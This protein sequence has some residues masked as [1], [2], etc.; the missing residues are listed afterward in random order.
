MQ[1]IHAL[2][3]FIVENDMSIAKKM[4]T[5]ALLSL[6]LAAMPALADMHPLQM[7]PAQPHMSA[8]KDSGYIH[9]TDLGI[10]DHDFTI[11]ISLYAGQYNLNTGEC[12]VGDP[13]LKAT[14]DVAAGGQ[15][16]LQ[17]AGDQFAKAGTNFTCAVESYVDLQAHKKRTVQYELIPD[18]DHTTYIATAQW[19]NL[20][21][22]QQH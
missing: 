8:A 9:L 7:V 20:N 18:V 22:P 16:Y 1:Y 2:E 14:Q 5:S 17:L 4:L 3:L 13:I 10:F 11:Q 6:S 12:K 21:Y 15:Y 19:I